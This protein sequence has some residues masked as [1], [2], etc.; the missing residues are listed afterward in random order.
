M[1]MILDLAEVMGINIVA[2]K[3][4]FKFFKHFFKHFFSLWVCLAWVSIEVLDRFSKRFN[5]LSFIWKKG[6]SDKQFGQYQSE[7]SDFSYSYFLMPIKG[8]NNKRILQF[9]ESSSGC[10]VTVT[11]NSK[12]ILLSVLEKIRALLWD[13]LSGKQA[14]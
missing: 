5:S 4:F 14:K 11:S 10:P 8:W 13:K 3:W 2:A 7:E 6:N 12:F 9:S 1:F